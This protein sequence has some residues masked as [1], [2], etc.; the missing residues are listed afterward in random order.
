VDAATNLISKYEL[1]YP[2]AVTGDEASEIYFTAYRKTG[3]LQVPSRFLWKLAGE[4]VADWTFDVAFDPQISDATF[5]A[6]TAGFHA[7][8]ANAAQQR[9]IG[10]EKIGDGVYL[11]NNLGGGGYNTMAVEFADHVVVVEA[12][13]GSQVSERAIQ[14]I[15][16]AIPGKPIR[17]VA[18]T[19]HH[20]DHSGGLRAFLAEGASVVTTRGNENY[21]KSLAASKQLRDAFAGR[22][23]P[24]RLEFVEN[25]KRVFTDG[26]QVLELY[27]IGPNPHAREM[28]IAYLPKQ[29]IVFQGDMFFSPF[30]GQPV[31]FAQETTRDFAVKLRELG[32]TVDKLAGVH[33]KVG[34]M[35]EL[36]QA[37]ELAKGMESSAE[38]GAQR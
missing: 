2:D 30:D 10:V 33:G 31:G 25:K 20:S 19:H 24:L 12:P 29:R 1:I 4:V 14:E 17:Y 38:A 28:L 9:Q 22:N 16:G 27:D 11:V 6:S 35:S 8:P 3:P 34:T 37:L 5:E 26:T 32:L 21:V 23:A 13:I 18:V 15:K 7:I 36:Q